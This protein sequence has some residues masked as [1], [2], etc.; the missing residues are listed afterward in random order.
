MKLLSILLFVLV[1]SFG[2][3]AQNG[4]PED[5]LSKEFHKERREALRAKMPA[6]SVAV[7]FANPVRNRA[8]D[9]DYVYHQDPNFYYL[10]GYRE[11]HAVLVMFSESQNVSEEK[12]Y[13]EKLYVQQR[14]PQAE[15][16]TGRRLGTEGAKAELG[17]ENAY[18]GSEFMTSGIDFTTF[19][20]VMY[21][22]F[23]DD[24]RDTRDQADLYDLVQ[25]FKTQ[26]KLVNNY[27]IENKTDAIE[28]DANANIEAET[29]KT[30]T[31]SLSTLMAGLRE[32][33]TEDE[34]V[35]LKKAVRI[36]AMG[37]ARNHESHAPRNV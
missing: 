4:I 32:I 19:D 31:R 8:N 26:I 22:D 5:Y 20:K 37:T 14:N 29:V 27:T 25:S 16:W 23:R 15:Q 1:F 11:P 21:T 2:S 24:Y 9:V 35:L 28:V 36:S 18:N 10:S 7:F 30:D 33:K 34:L 17:F 13:N 6:N 12:P 3:I